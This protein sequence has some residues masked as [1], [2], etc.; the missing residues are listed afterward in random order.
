MSRFTTVAEAGAVIVLAFALSACSREAAKTADTTQP[1]ATASET[2]PAETAA[3]LVF[4]TDFGVG[5]LRAGM[6]LD[7]ARRVMP[8]LR[9]IAGTDSTSCSY[10]EW[11]SAP[12]GV[13]V[14]FDGGRLARF[15]IDS[16]GVRTEA[17]AQVGDAASR[18]DSLY[19]GRLTR[20]PH[21]Y[22]D[23]E[24]FVVAPMRTADSLF[25]LVFEVEGGRVTRFRVGTRPQVEYV[26]G[27]S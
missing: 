2:A 8:E 19:T 24:Y 9:L 5:D 4:V 14:M 18:V 13:L 17:G 27:C 15:E 6:T 25:R 11:P 21:K 16:A 7:E 3:P 10:L 12:P 23:G 20:Q 22:T 26:E 1:V